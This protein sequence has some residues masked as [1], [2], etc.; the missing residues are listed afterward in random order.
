MKYFL[1]FEKEIIKNPNIHRT[2][3][4]FIHNKK[5]EIGYKN[6]EVINS[7][8]LFKY[9]LYSQESNLLPDC[10]ALDDIVFDIHKNS[11]I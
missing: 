11:K 5:N 1:L 7:I 8:Y 6:L 3:L 2:I 10:K 4:E 9:L